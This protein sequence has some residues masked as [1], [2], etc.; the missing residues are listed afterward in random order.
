MTRLAKALLR[1]WWDPH[2]ALAHARVGL[3]ESQASECSHRIR[4]WSKAVRWLEWL[5]GPTEFDWRPPTLQ[6]IHETMECYRPPI[7]NKKERRKLWE[8]LRR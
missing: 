1:Y 8:R 2:V 3:A 4:E 6:E 7:R 5:A